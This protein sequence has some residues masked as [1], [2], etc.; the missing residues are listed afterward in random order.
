[1]IAFGMNQSTSYITHKFLIA[2]GM[3]W[4]TAL[5][6]VRMA[7]VHP[8]EFT[9]NWSEVVAVWQILL[10]VSSQAG[11]ELLNALVILTLSQSSFN[12]DT[13][14]G[15]VWRT[16]GD[17]H[18]CLETFILWSRIRTHASLASLHAPHVRA[19]TTY[20]CNCGHNR[21]QDRIQR[22]YKS[23]WYLKLTFLFKYSI[24]PMF[25]RVL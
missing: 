3:N 5:I 12:Y 21:F 15:R 1:M 2:S 4:S 18:R 11:L 7:T 20:T 22:I 9:S 19:L 14:H 23:I 13:D 25:H 6:S 24:S 17:W 10:F 16:L 8:G